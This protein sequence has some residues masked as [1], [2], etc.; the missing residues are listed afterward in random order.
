MHSYM[1]HE[2]CVLQSSSFQY[3][4][5][6]CVSQ[7]AILTIVPKSEPF[8]NFPHSPFPSICDPLYY[9]HIPAQ[10]GWNYNYRIAGN[11]RW[12]K[13]SLVQIFTEK[14]LRINFRGFYFCG[15]W[16][17]LTTPLLVDATSLERLLRFCWY[18]VQ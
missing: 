2:V 5:K 14:R 13:F 6:I 16:D 4:H 12:R 18:F 7:V 15:T 11:F 9:A 1:V 8:P 3:H 17:A 10:L